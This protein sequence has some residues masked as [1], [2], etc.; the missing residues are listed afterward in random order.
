[1]NKI[2]KYI[3]LRTVIIIITL[4]AIVSHPHSDE[5]TEEKHFEL[6]E[7]SYSFL[8]IIRLSFHENDDENL[9]NLLFAQYGIIKHLSNNYKHSK[10]VLFSSSQDTVE[11]VAEEGAVKWNTN[12]FER[13]FFIKLNRLRG[14]PLFT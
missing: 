6:H 11:K 4:H 9:D 2:F 1:M 10:I 14:P 3:L 7:K 13:L 8:G 5:L 12:N